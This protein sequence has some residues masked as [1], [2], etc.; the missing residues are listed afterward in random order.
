MGSVDR[1]VKGRERSPGLPTREW[2]SGTLLCPGWGKEHRGWG[3][4]VCPDVC[5]VGVEMKAPR[6]QGAVQPLVSELWGSS[7]P[8]S[9]SP[10]DC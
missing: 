1:S 8:F 3:E 7:S 10:H 9:P 4:G 5:F 2:G 6:F